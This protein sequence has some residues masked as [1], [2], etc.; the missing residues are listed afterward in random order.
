MLRKCYE[1]VGKEQRKVSKQMGVH[2]KKHA[3]EDGVDGQVGH[4]ESG[5]CWETAPRKNMDAGEK[6]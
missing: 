3:D 1:N 2:T 5:R 4:A 6:S